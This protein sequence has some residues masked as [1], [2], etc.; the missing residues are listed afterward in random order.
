[1]T[2]VLLLGWLLAWLL[3]G[4]G[5]WFGLVILYKLAQKRGGGR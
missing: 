2:C 5:L 3:V 1:M 4:A